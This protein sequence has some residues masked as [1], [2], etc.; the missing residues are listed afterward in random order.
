MQRELISSTLP[1]K[2]SEKRMGTLFRLIKS[3]TARST[4]LMVGA[5]TLAAGLAFVAI[6]LVARGL[7]PAEFGVFSALT[8]F[9]TLVAAVGDVGM[10]TAL[11]RF[12]PESIAGEEGERAGDYL[13]AAMVCMGVMAVGLT[14][15]V[16]GGA[17]W[18]QRG[19][20]PNAEVGWLRVAGA[21]V[22]LALIFGFLTSSLQ[23]YQKFEAAA[24]VT[25]TYGVIRL[26]LVGPLWY[27]G[28]L[29]LE[30][31]IW[32]F[33]LSS[34]LGVVVGWGWLP[35]RW[36]WEW[37]RKKTLKELLGFSGWMGVN[38]TVSAVYSRLDVVLLNRLG[39]AYQ[40]GIYSAAQ[41]MD[42]FFVLL[43]NSMA[44]VFAPR[45]VQLREENQQRRFVGKM[46]LVVGGVVVGMLGLVVLA[47]WV[48]RIFFGEKYLGATMAI[49]VVL[50]V[51]YVLKKP[52][53]IAGLSVVQLG[54][55]LGVNWW[56][57]P[58]WGSVAP[59]VAWGMAQMVTLV[60]CGWLTGRW[61]LSHES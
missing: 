3:G 26:A 5:N 33:S 29:T 42:S 47:P 1:F 23:A 44:A 58:R 57:I 37:P 16:I 35:V 15:I 17:T 2:V 60:V 8:M 21:G 9:I 50:P 52:Q 59:A 38:Q 22:G 61:M 36:K 13:R 43:I 51:V 6:L 32:I 30:R 56:L 55:I 40:A 49:P 39:G 53:V 25:L 24:G 10:G 41:R 45:L 27:W 28:E 19:V 18:W 11:V 46:A 48:L 31:A 54:I 7:E 14:V 34:V 4:Y 20:F 12:I